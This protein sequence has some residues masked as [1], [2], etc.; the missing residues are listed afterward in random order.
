M[1]LSQD[2]DKVSI[3]LDAKVKEIRVLHERLGET[4]LVTRNMQGLN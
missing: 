1:E 3:A 4:D 2:R